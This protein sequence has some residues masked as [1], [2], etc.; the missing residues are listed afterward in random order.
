M[1]NHQNS[2]ADKAA[3][4]NWSVMALWCRATVIQLKH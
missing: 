3:S 2:G 4:D 1:A